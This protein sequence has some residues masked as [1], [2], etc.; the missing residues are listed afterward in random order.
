MSELA[1]IPRLKVPERVTAG[2]VFWVKSILPHPMESGLRRNESGQIIPRHIITRVTV[3]LHDETVLSADWH[4]GIS[5]N[6]YWEF[7]LKTDR[8][9]LLVM[10]WDDENGSRYRTEAQITVG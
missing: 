7:A 4:P 10:E 9:G 2:A 6:P 8:S 3:S 5:A 1:P